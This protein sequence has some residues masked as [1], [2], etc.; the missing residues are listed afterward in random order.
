MYRQCPVC[1]T[2]FQLPMKYRGCSKECC[3]A[4]K[5]GESLTKLVEQNGTL[6]EVDNA[7][8]RR[9]RS[10]KKPIMTITKV[11]ELA[12][13]EGISYGQYVAKYHV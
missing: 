2:F 11:I 1:G 12:R 7:I 6:K 10:R 9:K 5:Y 3:D 8:T 4:I 13:S